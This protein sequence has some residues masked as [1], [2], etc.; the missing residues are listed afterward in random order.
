MRNVLPVASLAAALAACTSLPWDSVASSPESAT[1]DA[2]K[3]VAADAP[4]TRLAQDADLQWGPC[5]DIFPAGCEIAV[6]HGDPAQPNADV[7]L[8]VPGGVVLP[9]HSHSSAERMVLVSGELDVQYQGFRATRLTAG[10]YAFGPAGLP[11]VAKC[12]STDPC[13]LFIAFEG[14]VDALPFSGEIQ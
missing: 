6:L 13:V 11:H 14:P 10:E 2:I 9:P 4:L 1:Q 12:E 7:F 3:R 8:R 5:P